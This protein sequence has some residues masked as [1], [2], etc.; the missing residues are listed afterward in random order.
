M[1]FLL[2]ALLLSPRHDDP[3]RELIGNLGD[4]DPGVREA[5]SAELRKIGTAALPALEAAAADPDDEVRVRAL[6]LLHRIQPWRQARQG[7]SEALGWLARH[8]SADGSWSS[9]MPASCCAKPPPSEFA[10]DDEFATG[11][12]GL[13]LLALVRG[14]ST[15]TSRETARRAIAWITEHQGVDG[16]IGEHRHQGFA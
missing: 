8:Q 16:Q 1:R 2:L 5:A 12:T 4:N 13:S 7:A 3:V 15:A 9:R 11:L 14:E 6:E 10:S